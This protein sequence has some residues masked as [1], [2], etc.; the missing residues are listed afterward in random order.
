MAA[1]IECYL[2]SIL[3]KTKSRSKHSA[4]HD[5]NTRELTAVVPVEV[6]VFKIVGNNT[7]DLSLTDSPSPLLSSPLLSSS[8]SGKRCV[9]GLFWRHGGSVRDQDGVTFPRPY[10]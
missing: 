1:T 10:N 3:E 6:A 4:A 5:T 9:R 8:P 2:W 7:R